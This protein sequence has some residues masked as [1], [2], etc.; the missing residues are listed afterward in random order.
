MNLKLKLDRVGSDLTKYRDVHFTVQKDGTLPGITEEESTTIDRFAREWL[1]EN[2]NADKSAK[3]INILKQ[4][5]TKYPGFEY[6]IAT[7]CHN[8]LTA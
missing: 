6:R 8:L 7:D 2:L 5:K 1:K 4:L 3:I